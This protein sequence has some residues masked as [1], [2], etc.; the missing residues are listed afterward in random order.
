MMREPLTIAL[1][2]DDESVRDSLPALLRQCGYQVEAFSGAREFL[3]SAWME[4][5]RC[6]VL[7]V[8][9][10]GMSGPEL[11]QELKRRSNRTP[12]IFITAYSDETLRHRLLAQG[13]VG[14]LTK[15][16]SESDLLGAIEAALAPD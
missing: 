4:E 7:D 12:I 8:A 1:V 6:L 10:P 5:A 14:C 15:P 3:A 16:F 2:D 11:Q 13:A 9:M